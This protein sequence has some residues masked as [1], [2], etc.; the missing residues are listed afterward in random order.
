[1]KNSPHIISAAL[2]KQVLQKYSEFKYISSIIESCITSAQLHNATIM[3]KIFSE[4]YSDMDFT[5]I[6]EHIALEKKTALSDE[7][8]TKKADSLYQ[9]FILANSKS[10]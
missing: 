6:L 8:A 10:N 2:I 9:A 7:D 3:I 1:M 5:I 4:K